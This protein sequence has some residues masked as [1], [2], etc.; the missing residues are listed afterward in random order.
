M[1]GEEVQPIRRF[2]DDARMGV[3]SC[4]YAKDHQGGGRER[5]GRVG[6]AGTVAEGNWGGY[7]ETETT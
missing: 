6:E 2:P 4:G 5:G 3:N 1:K 7:S